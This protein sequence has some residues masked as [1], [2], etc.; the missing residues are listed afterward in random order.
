MDIRKFLDLLLFILFL[1]LM[2]FHFLPRDVH[3]ILGVAMAA[4][5]LIHI[6]INLKRFF[7]LIQSGTTKGRIFT[8]IIDLILFGIF[9]ANI[10]AGIFMSNYLFHDF[11]PLELHRDMTFHQIHYP[12]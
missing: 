2:S 12:K 9:A 3:E 6:I 11:I 4:G 10:I 7:S 1:L 5:V 8:F